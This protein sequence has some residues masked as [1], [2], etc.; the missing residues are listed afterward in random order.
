MEKEQQEELK[1]AKEEYNRTQKELF[2]YVRKHSTQLSELGRLN[3]EHNRAQKKLEE[4]TECP[5]PKDTK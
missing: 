3:L 4:L 2:D 1:K 5:Y